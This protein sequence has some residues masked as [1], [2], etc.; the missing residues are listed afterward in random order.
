MEL[1]PSALAVEPG[2]LGRI[3]VHLR[4]GGAEPRDVVVEVPSEERDWTWVHPE[5]CPVIPG[6]EAVV[7]VFFKPACGPHPTAGKHT[8]EIVARA[9]GEAPAAG[10]GIVDVGT[11]VDAAGALDPMVAHNVGGHSYTFNLENLGNVPVS[12]ALSTDDPSGA[13]QVDV[14]PTRVSAEPGQTA[15]ALVSVQARKKLKKGEQR[16]RVCVL[17]Q[18]DGGSELR[19]EGAFYQ[20]GVK[21][22]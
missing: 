3:D 9:S 2:R 13:L 18:V 14:Q 5:S 15:A 4:N 8:I 16:Y 17:A 19:I 10:Q 6:E 22:K 20:Q 12:A 21:G 11:Y 7:T 1:V